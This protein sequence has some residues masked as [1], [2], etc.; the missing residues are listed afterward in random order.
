[1]LYEIFCLISSKIE[2][3]EVSQAIGKIEE[4]IKNQGGIIVDK[5]ELGE[6]KLAYPIKKE[7]M[8]YGLV[9][10]FESGTETMKLLGEKLKTVSE[11]IRFQ[12]LRTK[13]PQTE[14]KIKTEK[15]SEEKLTTETK[16]K[17]F[18][19]ELPQLFDKLD[20]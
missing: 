15:K 18:D 5:K 9:I 17:D 10:R 20:I 16:K 14:K 4:A 13:Q 7:S 11:I 12:I 8:G 2:E 19:L 3:K 1:M 6:K